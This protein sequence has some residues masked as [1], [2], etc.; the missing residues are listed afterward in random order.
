M[1]LKHEDVSLINSMG[2]MENSSALF[3]AHVSYVP[4]VFGMG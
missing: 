3:I 1:T 4:A 2:R